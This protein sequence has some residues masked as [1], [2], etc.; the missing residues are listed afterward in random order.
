MAATQLPVGGPTTICLEEDDGGK[1]SPRKARYCR[2]VVRKPESD[3]FN[4]RS[5]LAASEALNAMK[6]DGAAHVEA[7]EQ[8]GG[9]DKMTQGEVSWTGLGSQCTTP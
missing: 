2:R 5:D 9:P 1:T 4:L 3:I 6:E 8:L 7:T